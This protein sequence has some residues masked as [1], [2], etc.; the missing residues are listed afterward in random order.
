MVFTQNPF[1]M[2]NLLFPRAL[3]FAFLLFINDIHLSLNNATIKSFADDANFLLARDNFDLL[4]VT[5][6]SEL[7]SFQEWVHA[8]E[9]TMNYDPQK[10]SYSV[11]KPR[12]KQLPYSFKSSLRVGG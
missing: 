9:L 10:S 11:F 6:T 3:S 8:S 1:S 12:K 5:V 7:Q 4:C 2:E